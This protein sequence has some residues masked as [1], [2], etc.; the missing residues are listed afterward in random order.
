MSRR[1]VA[2][3]AAEGH[4]DP[5]QSV[6]SAVAKAARK[7]AQATVSA[8][9]L[10]DRLGLNRKTVSDYLAALA[11]GGYLA[12][13]C[14]PEVSANAALY[15]LTRDAG[16]HAPRL[17]RDGSPVT[18]GAGTENMWRSMRMLPR[19]SALE[20]AAHSTTETVNVSEATAQ[21]YCSILSRTGF[22]RVVQ[23]ADPVRGRKAVYKLVRNTGPRPPMIQR[24]K[25]VFDPNTREV[26]RPGDTRGGAA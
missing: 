10:A 1:S 5:R 20:L 25:Q 15:R 7:D 24:V 21:S 12:R 8:R 14:G 9:V 19:F 16:H 23:K 13:L 3:M 26:H 22:L 2:T 6:W 4:H 17:R 18:Q 11:A